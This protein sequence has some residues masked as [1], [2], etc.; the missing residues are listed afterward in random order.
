MHESLLTSNLGPLFNYTLVT[1]RYDDSRLNG[2]KS[3]EDVKGNDENLFHF[4]QLVHSVDNLD[5]EGDEYA[6]ELSRHSSQSQT[7]DTNAGVRE[8]HGWWVMEMRERHAETGV[9]T[10]R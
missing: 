1:S 9:G 5:G 2:P 8:K 6:C 3:G 10:V 7:V 4:T